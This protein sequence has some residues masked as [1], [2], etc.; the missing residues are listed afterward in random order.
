MYCT[1]EL[2]LPDKKILENKVRELRELSE[3]EE[4][5]TFD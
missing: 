1:Y 2:H 4:I 5:K 3:W